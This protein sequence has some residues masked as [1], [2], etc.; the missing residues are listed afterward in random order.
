MSFCSSKSDFGKKHW[1]DGA[2]VTAHLET[3]SC[4]GR[5]PSIHF[6]PTLKKKSSK[7][8]EKKRRYYVF[9]RYLVNISDMSLLILHFID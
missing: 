8:K 6:V 7:W 2:N 3:C 5:K 1:V 9:S 4:S